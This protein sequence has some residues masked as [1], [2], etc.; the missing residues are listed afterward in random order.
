[1]LQASR[2]LIL[3]RG[4]KN[5]S[6]VSLSSNGLKLY[7]FILLDVGGDNYNFVKMKILDF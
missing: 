1:M 5:S 6:L 7:N 2:V 3:A 4:K